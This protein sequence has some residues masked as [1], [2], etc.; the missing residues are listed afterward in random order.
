MERVALLENRLNHVENQASDYWVLATSYS[1]WF[2]QLGFLLLEAGSVMSKNTKS[3]MLKNLLDT[4]AGG[5]VW[6]LVGFYVFLY[7]GVPE[8][9]SIASVVENGDSSAHSLFL[10]TFAFANCAS[11]IASGGSASR[12]KI[13]AHMFLV[14][15]LS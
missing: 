1:I 2:M 15:V 11:T 8:S 14:C 5:L 9:P 3:I 4:F 6:Y 12:M 13:S 10:Q 7:F